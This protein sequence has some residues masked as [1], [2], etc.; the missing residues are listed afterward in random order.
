MQLETPV[1]YVL[2][3]PGG[4]RITIRE[5]LYSSQ[6]DLDRTGNCFGIISQ[7]DALNLPAQID[8]VPATDVSVVMQ[9]GQLRGFRIK[10][11]VY[12]PQDIWHERQY[13]IPGLEVGLSPVA[14]ASWSMG[15][16]ASLDQ[17]VVEWLDNA[18][19]PSVVMKNTMKQLNPVQ[20]KEMKD[21]Y[22][23]TV[24]NGDAFVIGADWEFSPYKAEMTGLNWLAAKQYENE[25]IARFFNV[26]HDL[27]DIA[28]SG[29]AGSAKITYAN[30]GQR[31]LQFLIMNLQPTI[32]A[33]EEALSNGLLP[34]G[35]SDTDQRANRY[36][37][38]NTDSLLR[39]D[40]VAMQALFTAQI[41]SHVK[42][43]NEC[44]ELLNLPP[45]TTAQL[46]E[47]AAL[48]TASGPPQPIANPNAKGLSA[49]AL[50]KKVKQALEYVPIDSVGTTGNG[51]YTAAQD[52]YHCQSCCPTV[53]SATAVGS[54]GMG[55]QVDGQPNGGMPEGWH[56]MDSG[57]DCQPGCECNPIGMGCIYGDDGCQCGCSEDDPDP[58]ASPAYTPPKP[59]GE[60]IGPGL[61]PLREQHTCDHAPQPIHIHVP[62]RSVT[63]EAPVIHH[64]ASDV[65]PVVNITSPETTIKI[66]NETDDD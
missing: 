3:F 34:N 60:T 9:G 52:S 12:D 8:L 38:F 54:P 46:A 36:V 61:S 58:R 55:S 5:W 50:R 41:A 66:V 57:C 4:P 40:P 31:N 17:F 51:T 13:T 37:K 56:Q 11:I 18:T 33:R 15:I 43:P 20:A 62:E 16:Y 6:V 26:P 24:A 14:Y 49:R 45:L 39:L 59:P 65:N 7:R 1:P 35:I 53:P 21:S 28:S 19:Q 2:R 42:T 23:A 25:D 47:L 27:L 22:R 32:I 10:G 44:R 30:I 29:S 48:A 63:V 64:Y